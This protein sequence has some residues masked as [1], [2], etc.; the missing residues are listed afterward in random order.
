MEQTDDPRRRFCAECACS[1]FLC[2][3][4]IEAALRAEQNECVAIPARMADHLET[5]PRA[6]IAG[7]LD[8]RHTFE[9]AYRAALG[10]DEQE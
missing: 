10:G 7:Q 6:I 9:Q 5:D 4:V 8:Y 1:V 3:D 2:H